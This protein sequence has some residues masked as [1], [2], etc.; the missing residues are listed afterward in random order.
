MPPF[1]PGDTIRLRLDGD[2][3][4]R[5]YAIV[6]PFLPFTKSVVVLAR[7]VE[8][9]GEVVIKVYDPR[10]LGERARRRQGGRRRGGVG[11]LELHQEEENVE[12]DA[13]TAVLWEEYFYRTCMA[14]FRDET[15]AYEQ[16]SALQGS[17]I[18]RLLARGVV[19]DTDYRRAISCPAI[20]LEYL[21]GVAMQDAQDAI[22]DGARDAWIQLARTVERLR[23]L[24]I[25]H[26][27]INEGNILLCPAVAPCRA[28]LIDFGMARSGRCRSDVGRLEALLRRKGI[29]II[30]S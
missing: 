24:E 18:P 28:V 30:S 27:D 10:F 23:E 5:V 22:V 16:L 7:D 4:E 19:V 25:V 21:D 15:R 29:C 12:W 17:A 1:Q 6:R 8:E 13:E 2:A 11:E 20:V 26:S 3:T 14:S 9:C